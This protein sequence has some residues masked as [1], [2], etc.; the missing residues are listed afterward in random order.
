MFLYLFQNEPPTNMLTNSVFYYYFHSFKITGKQIY[1]TAH[2]MTSEQKDRFAV[3]Y[4][5]L[6]KY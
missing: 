3:Q 2:F 1:T 5:I 4:Q 6:R